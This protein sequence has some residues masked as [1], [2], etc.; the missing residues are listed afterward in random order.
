M[1]K[2]FLLCCI[3]NCK[4]L[5]VSKKSKN[6]YI[7]E[8]FS[9]FSKKRRKKISYL[10]VIQAE[11]WKY[12][13]KFLFITILLWNFPKRRYKDFFKK[14]FSS[15]TKKNPSNISKLF[16]SLKKNLTKKYFDPKYLSWYLLIKRRM[17]NRASLTHIEP[18]STNNFISEIYRTPWI[19][20]LRR[21]GFEA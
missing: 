14:I 10:F 9:D 5:Q 21:V 17:K 6:M 13:S 12:L 2:T 20:R 8:F 15:I 16:P 11:Y 19:R 7:L 3:K 1:N 4:S 18:V